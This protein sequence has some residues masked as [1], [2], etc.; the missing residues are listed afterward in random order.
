L[1]EKLRG[2]NGS[3]GIVAGLIDLLSAM[4]LLYLF[5]VMGQIDMLSVMGVGKMEVKTAINTEF[6]R[7][8][9][10]FKASKYN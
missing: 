8:G 4:L 3:Q 10:E 7:R 2:F 5:A 9:S 6:E 1:Q